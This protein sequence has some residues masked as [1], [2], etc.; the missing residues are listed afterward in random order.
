MVVNPLLVLTLLASGTGPARAAPV[1]VGGTAC[2]VNRTADRLIV[3]DGQGRRWRVSLSPEALVTF[4][5]GRYE[6]EDVRPGDRVRVQGVEVPGRLAVGRLDVQV[7]V[8][9]ALLD[10]VLKTRPRLVGRFAV[11]EAKTEFFSLR[12]PGGDYVRVDAKA[13]YGPQ[14]RMWVSRFRSGDLLELDGTWTK[15]KELKASYIKVLTDEEPSSCRSRARRGEAKEATAA[16]EAEEQRFLE[17]GDPEK[18]AEP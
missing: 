6:A 14:G 7:K 11:R 8:A 5:G 10:A 3:D 1:E 15:E 9:E 18:A 2:R 16:R 12:V 4:E 17:G 13:A